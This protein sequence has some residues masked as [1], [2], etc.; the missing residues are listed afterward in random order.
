MGWLARFFKGVGYLF[1]ALD[2]GTSSLK[3]VQSERKGS[4]F[5][6][7]VHG[8]YEYK[9]QVFAGSEII[10]EFELV[11]SIRELYEQLKIKDKQ[12]TIHVPLHACFYSVISIPSGKDPESAVIDY[13]KSLISAEEFRQVKIDYRILPV[14]VEKGTIDIAIAAVKQEFLDKRINLLRQ[15]GLEPTVIDIEPAA[16][17]NQF[18]L[19]NPDLT[20]VPVCLIDIGATYTKI[21]ISFGG[22]PYITR[23]I[24]YGGISLTE[25]IQKELMLSFEDAE[26]LKE[27]EPVKEMDQSSIDS[28]VDDFFKKIVTEALWT[29]ENFKDRF[30]LEVESV[31]LYGGSAKLPDAAKR[32]E[33]FSGKPTYL[34]SPLSFSGIVDSEEF[35]VAAGL[36]IRYKGD[37][38]AKV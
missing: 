32:V 23:N 19:N 29:V 18:Y 8:I 11:R 25:Q 24:E 26:R 31:Y 33:R 3:L 15:A 2:I 30:N 27:G 16:I 7:K 37:G 1:P 9:E 13:M 5:K 4:N 35:A 22:Y 38:N 10:D 17:N 14:A 20:P 28:I 36:S 34:G 21:V 6:V 12:V